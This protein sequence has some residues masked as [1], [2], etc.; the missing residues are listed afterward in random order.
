MSNPATPPEHFGRGEPIPGYRTVSLLGRG[1]YGEVWRA[2]APGG[3]SKAVKI[4]FGGVGTS[5]AETELRALA[6][7]KDVRHP[8]L[9]SIERIEVVEGN[10][11][12]VTELADCSLKEH[13][14]RLREAQAPGIPQTELMRYVG[15][16]AEA[17]DFLYDNHSLQHLDV[18][19]ENILIISNRAKLGDFGLVK[20]LYERSAS[21]V[22]GL[23]PTY[24]PP[25]LF[26]GKPNRNSDQYSLALV[27]MQML[28]G[29][30]PFPA[31]N[32]AQIA[33][34][35]LHGVPDLSALPKPQRPVIARALSKDPLKRFENCCAMVT[36]LQ[37]AV[38]SA[39]LPVSPPS[40]PAAPATSFPGAN[41]ARQATGESGIS[42]GS[43]SNRDPS[44]QDSE[45]LSGSETDHAVREKRKSAGGADPLIL[46]G[47]GGAGIDVLGGVLHRL[48]DRYGATDNWPAVE[49]LAL[50]STTR[51]GSSRFRESDYERVQIVPIPLKAAENYSERAGD[52]LKWIGRRWLYNI[53]R[54]L[55][56]SGYRPLGRLALI[57]HAARVREAIRSVVA[58]VAAQAGGG[59]C[60]PRVV[61][62]GSICGGTA[63]GTLFDLSYAIRGALKQQGLSDE[64]VH[65]VLLTSAPRSNL[66]RDKARA[67]AYAALSELH[68]FSAPG[69]HYPGEPLLAA[70]PFHGDNATF[71]R[72]HLLQLGDCPG[73]AGWNFATDQVAEFVYSMSFTPAGTVLEHGTHPETGGHQHPTDL[74]AY[75][76]L[77]LG[78]DSART[79][80]QAVHSAC[81]DVV[82]LWREG[83]Q[84]Q[85]DSTN[86]SQIT[87]RI[88]TFS[89]FG[90][91]QAPQT[92]DAAKQFTDC[93]LDVD[94]LVRD[95]QEVVQLEVGGTVDAFVRKLVED[96]LDIVPQ[97]TDETGRVAMILAMI[98]RFLRCDFRE[99]LDQLGEDQF[100][101]QVLGRL[102]AQTRPRVKRMLD[103][104]RQLVDVPE[105]RIEGARQNAVA[106]QHLLQALQ[107]TALAQAS[108]LHR[109]AQGIST[110]TRGE[111]QGRPERSRFSGWS[112]RRKDPD[113]ELRE[114]LNQYA[115]TRL[116][117]L[118]TR[119]AARL[120]RVIET[121]VATLLE[122][123]HR[124]SRDLTLLATP[125]RN[126]RGGT[127]AVAQDDELPEGFAPAVSAYRQMLRSQLELRR[128]DIARRIDESVE[129]RIAT[130][131]GGLRR[132]LDPQ[133]DLQ[134]QLGSVLEEASRQ[135]VLECIQN[136]NCHLLVA[137]T[138]GPQGSLSELIL[139]M[140][141]GLAE[142]GVTPAGA[143]SRV[144][145][146][147]DEADSDSLRRQFQ[148]PPLAATV[149]SGRKCDVTL[150]SLR[151]QF[152]I[153][154]AA[155]EIIGGVDLYK[156]LAGRLHTRVDIPWQQFV[157][158]APAARS[159]YSEGVTPSNPSKTSVIPVAARKADQ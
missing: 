29:T 48:H 152:P 84:W 52:Y 115:K 17:L 111:Q 117:E 9:L 154:V 131:A 49:F 130:E 138:P 19:P 129:K 137:G 99:G 41:Q 24:A 132:L 34:Q 54:D 80:T 28:T 121:E 141:Q 100:F 65:G 82:K 149:I 35:H 11:V 97:S 144:L 56:T 1:G 101:V 77:S 8:L 21:L 63:S 5:H 32:T 135:V 96:S 133:I 109:T 143:M 26:E 33:A 90:A 73:E 94:H 14:L 69:S 78:V 43:S 6:R 13:F 12:I 39:D 31:T 95:G 92:D 58:R 146:V 62:V 87:A 134:Q 50:D 140:A 126:V 42:G 57:T 106:A 23:T 153:A 15:D 76:L 55:T 22:G 10:L 85:P 157:V 151:S 116:Q 61:I 27:Y 74:T 159:E 107:E 103:W 150:C 75:Q 38:R 53:A 36:A 93:K 155:H 67:N 71:A 108:A 105:L 136:I 51:P 44:L 47:V 142:A 86:S 112:L 123:F 98:D 7:V 119:A 139:L 145:I 158:R 3:I 46:V 118:L 125:N 64:Q 124:F 70:P 127:Q 60:H 122:Q 128:Y 89:K 79:V 156:E 18:K 81:Q 91:S 45:K 20:H 37:E 110:T 114:V 147:P 148:T 102:T 25:E 72:T 68:H 120:C 113:A 40:K 4:V 66:D 88:N 59:D 16:A 83:R 2:I 30:L 104:I